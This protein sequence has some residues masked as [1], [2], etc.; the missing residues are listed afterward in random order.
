MNRKKFNAS[1]FANG[2]LKEL[3]QK[4]ESMRNDADR[5]VDVSFRDM[6]EVE[7][8][9]LTPE[10]FYEEAGID[11]NFDTLQNLFT[12]P[13]SSVRWLIPEIFRDALRLGYRQSPLWPAV[14]A[15]EQQVSQLSQI[16][17]YLNMSDASPKK[18]GEGETIPVG[19]LSYGQRS[20][21]IWKFGRGIK[22]T[23]EVQRYVA[24]SV[25][26]IYLEDF[27][28]KLGYGVDTMALKTL[29]NGEQ[30]AGPNSNAAPIIGIKDTGTGF[31]FR[32]LLKLWIRMAKI[33]RAPK[34]MISDE[35]FAL[36]LLDMDQFSKKETGTTKYNLNI[37]TPMPQGADM[38]INGNM[39]ANTCLVVDPSKALIKMN[40]VPLT[41]E[42][43]RIVSNQTAAFYA[44]VTT[45]FAKMFDDASAILKIDSEIVPGGNFDFPEWF[46]V[47]PEAWVSM[48]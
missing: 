1:R 8:S 28:T 48:D 21:K 34:V 22:V 2:K 20:F 16:L 33:G 4:A 27:G 39:A 7:F 41:V 18:V 11:L 12:T 46:D 14:T 13:D 6:L 32:D 3:V 29:I 43:E 44:S 26:S 10:T 17:P 47:D 31:E 36:D 35:D 5:P 24:L 38:Y 30:P 25:V 45:G 40:A 37:K 42:S 9:G 19:T 15:V 23:D